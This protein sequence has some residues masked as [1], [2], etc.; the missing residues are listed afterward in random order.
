M[1]RRALCLRLRIQRRRRRKVSEYY[2][3]GFFLLKV[4]ILNTNLKC[5]TYVE[6]WT[7][8]TG[9]VVRKYK[10]VPTATLSAKFFRV[11]G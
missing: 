9:K 10:I 6:Q 11:W 4:R 1:M 7:Y 2:A 3:H 8:D 5:T